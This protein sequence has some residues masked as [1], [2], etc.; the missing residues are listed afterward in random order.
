MIDWL[1]ERIADILEYRGGMIA[2]YLMISA[3]AM[4][5]VMAFAWLAVSVIE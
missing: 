2:V 5:V 1:E 4:A 3:F